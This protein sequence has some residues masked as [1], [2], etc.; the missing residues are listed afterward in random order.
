MGKYSSLIE[1]E[2]VY[3]LFCDDTS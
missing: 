3:Y 2:L 1:S